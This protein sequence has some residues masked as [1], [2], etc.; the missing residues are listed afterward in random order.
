MK[1]HPGVN[2]SV[3]SM[4]EHRVGLKPILRR[5]RA[6]K[7]KQPIAYVKHK[8]EWTWVYG[9]VRP[10]T[11][12]TFW[13]ILPEVSTEAMN[14]ALQQFADDVK[15]SETNRVL[16]VL[17]QAGWHRSKELKLPVGIQLMFLPPYSPELQPAEK[18]WLPLDEPLVNKSLKKIE[19]VEGILAKRCCFLMTQQ[20]RM[21]CL[22]HFHWW[23]YYS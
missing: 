11:G 3:W 22:T 20:E 12:D 16:L 2:W 6:Q 18:L 23:T 17:D 1:K 9:F 5:V 4:D 8:Y 19:E 10:S 7:G 14:I 15:A 21:K 13:L